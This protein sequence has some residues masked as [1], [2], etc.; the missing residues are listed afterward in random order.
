MK[1]ELLTHFIF[2]I[3][4]FLLITLLKRWFDLVFLPFWFGGIL[5]TL[6]PDVDY[7]LQAYL[8]RPKDQMSQEIVSLV[9]QRRV[10]KI[11]DFVLRAKRN[12]PDLL[13]H[14]ASF[15]LIF[16]IFSFFIITSSAN[17]FGKGLVL[18]FLIH[19][20]LDE[21]VDLTENKNINPW[22]KGFFLN[23]DDEQKRWYLVGNGLTIVGL[24][25]L[26]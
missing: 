14:K 9:S 8:I 22:F 1:R 25:L 6:L 20:L 2:M 21:V 10:I 12:L 18:G 24:A 26:L 4:F 17:L 16:V 15:Q 11:L 7:F 19:L 5:G 13:V 23:L 3:A